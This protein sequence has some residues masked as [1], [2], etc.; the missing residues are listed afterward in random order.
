MPRAHLKAVLGLP[1]TAA[2]MRDELRLS[3]HTQIL[4]NIACMYGRRK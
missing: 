1:L 4:A 2:A 3:M